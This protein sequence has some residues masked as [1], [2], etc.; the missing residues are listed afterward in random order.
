MTVENA[1]PRINIGKV[2]DWLSERA[3][4]TKCPFCDSE[5]WSAV[6]G[7]GFVGSALPYGDGKGDMYMG[8]YPVLALLCRKCNFVR[9]IALTPDFLEQVIEDAP[10][11]AE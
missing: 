6:N 7:P 3:T 5:H 11:A 8:G 10:V 2:A 9:N 4:T 1:K